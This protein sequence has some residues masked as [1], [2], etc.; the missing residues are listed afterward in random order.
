VQALEALAA[1]LERLLE[2]GEAFLLDYA[3][4]ASDFVRLNRNRLRQAG[5]VT[6]RIATV[7]LL[8]GRRHA[9]G[10]C[11]LSG[12]PEQDRERLDA[13]LARLRALRAHVP[14]DP[15]LAFAT[16]ASERIEVHEP[17]LP[18]AG[19]A[20]ESLVE[21]ARGLD[22][23][24]VWASGLIERG[25][26]SSFG[27]R[28]WWSTRSFNLDWSCFHDGERAVKARYAGSRWSAEALERKLEGV[29]AG[30]SEVA[31]PART[32]VPGR[33]RVYLAP[34]ALRDLLAVV[35]FGGFGLR[36]HRTRRTPLIKLARGERTLHPLVTLREHHDPALVPHFTPGGFAKRERI[37]LIDEGRLGECLV[38]PRS[39]AEHG[40]E[41]ND[42]D[43]VPEALE[44]LPG[45]LPSAAARERLGTGL[46]VNNVWYCNFSDRSDCRLTGMTRFACLRVEGGRAVAPVEPMRFDES[47]YRILGEGLEG[48]TRE[49]ELLVDAHSYESRATSGYRL[50]GALVD[51]FLLTL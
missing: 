5:R 17:E 48:L 19:E 14:E 11:T 31:R 42:A 8:C 44:L 25:F 35:G 26:A 10:R 12:R 2:P 16:E 1:T 30:L 33:Y 22:L 27:V 13:L 18:P 28:H 7:D 4:E 47:L 6:Q 23:V 50:P 45:D 3:G 39:H 15:Y 51:G 40:V 41:V 29:R 34:A 24:G 37:T 49:R 9:S 46:E 20:I 32:L 43:E 21:R 36:G 38:D